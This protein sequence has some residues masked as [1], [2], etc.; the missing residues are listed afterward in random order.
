[1]IVDKNNLECV[2]TDIVETTPVVDVHTHLYYP[3]FSKLLLR[4]VDHLVTYHYLIAEALRYAPEKT[5]GFWDLSVKEQADFIWK[6]LFIDRS[7]VSESC[8]GILTT[9]KLFG[10]DP[11]TR[12]LPSY[13]QFFAGLSLEE[14]V[15]LVFKK[16]GI[17]YLVMTNDPFDPVERDY[18]LGNFK[19]DPRFRAALR[20]DPLLNNWP[21]AAARL[22][23]EGYQ[24]D[25]D[26]SGQTM[27]EVRRFLDKWAERMN[28]LYLAVSLPPTFRFPESSPRG[29]LLEEVILPF[30]RETNRP[31]APMIG[32]KKLVNPAL[33]LAGDSVGKA[34]IET[35]EY[36]CA[37]YPENKFFVTM[38]SRENQHEL[39]VAARKFGNLMIFGC[40]WFLNNPVLVEEMTRMRLELLGL[41]FIP[42]HSDARILDQL[43]YKWAHSRRII[44]RVLTDKYRDLLA[45]GWTVT[46]DEIRRDVERLF[47]RNFHDFL[48]IQDA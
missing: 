6:T 41:S 19:A 20:I 42:Q 35:I 12:D 44:T 18:W 30:C 40:W 34:E 45:T 43:L 31:F 32:V 46:E 27:A 28:P 9:L 37:N 22:Q 4:G 2:V 15:D 33:R 21:E 16:S 14:H 13:R 3:A 38:L 24:A 23:A 29:R 47:F 36:L 48:G 5:T 7:P 1:M 8:R 25:K 10:L 17:K 11:G 26:F 39:D